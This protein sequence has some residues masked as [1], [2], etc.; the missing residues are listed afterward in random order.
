MQN[1]HT[2]ILQLK[3][4]IKYRYPQLHGYVKIEMCSFS[5][6]LITIEFP[7][8]FENSRMVVIDIKRKFDYIA[9]R[10]MDQQYSKFHLF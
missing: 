2:K 3:N 1:T 8:A 4:H 9:F 6:D 5:K 7:L 10:D